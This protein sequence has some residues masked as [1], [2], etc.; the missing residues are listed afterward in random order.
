MIKLKL[1]D[2]NQKEFE[3]LLNQEM[4][5]T[6]KFLEKE[7]VA[8]R[9][10]RAHP[11]LVEDIKATVYENKLMRIKDLASISTPDPRM[12]LIQPWDKSIINEIEKALTNSDVG[13]KPTVESTVIRLYLPEMSMAR[14]EEM[15]KILSKKLEDAKIS[16]RNTRKDFLNLIRD[17][18]KAKAISEDHANRLTTAL[19]KITDANT[20]KC[21][22]MA[23]KKEKEIL[24]V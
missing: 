9:T 23:Q 18:E 24:T 16:I 13:V 10:G 5:K 21:Q 17:S 19:Q 11:A 12:I 20:E 7:L 15:R 1:T 8:I 22:A 4:D 14:R 2:T 3:T 6:I